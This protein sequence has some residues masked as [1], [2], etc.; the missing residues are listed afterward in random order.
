MKTSVAVKNI[1]KWFGKRP[2]T[3][4][5]W[6]NTAATVGMLAVALVMTCALRQNEKALKVAAE[7]LDVQKSEFRIQN[8]PWLSLEKVQLSGPG[9][10]LAGVE[11]PHTVTVRIMNVGTTPAIISTYV[12]RGILDGREVKKTDVQPIAISSNQISRNELFLTE[13]LYK[14]ITPGQHK[15][16]VKADIRYAGPLNVDPNAFYLEA[17]ASYL[18]RQGEFEVVQ[19]ILAEAH[20]N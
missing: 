11:Y 12:L 20:E 7:S 6:M 15:F 14:Q 5:M 4:A 3:K 10:D 1:M 18:Q 8:R 13:D 17:T 19:N 2:Y 9:Q 16:E